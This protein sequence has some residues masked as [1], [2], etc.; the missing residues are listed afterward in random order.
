VEPAQQERVHCFDRES[1]KPLWTHAYPVSYGGV[2]Y[3]AGPRASVTVHDGRA[4]A[5][6]A[7][8]NLACLDA[9]SGALLWSRDL[10][11]DYAIQMP[12]WGI[13]AAPLVEG[14]V[15]ILQ[16]GGK[17]ACIVGLDRKSGADRW[18]ALPD[19]ASYSAPIT[20]DQEGKRVVVC[21]TGDRVVGLDPASGALQWEFPFPA[22]R[23]P[24]AIATPVLDRGRL[25]FTSAIDG[26]LM[27]R[28]VPGRLAV[29]KVWQRRG[30]SERVTDS[31]H[32]LISTPI[33]EG[34]HLYGIDH[35]G[36]L[37]CLDA[38]TGDRI[39]ESLDVM[40]QARWATAHLVR[41]GDRTWILNER[42]EL[43][44]ARLT[45][46]G[47]RELSRARLLGPTTGQLPQRGGVTWSH[48]AFAHGH[49]FA[50][51]DNELVCAD[52]RK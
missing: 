33:L 22:T 36:E 34:D 13:A 48:P 16:I 38:K 31:L 21:L 39:W 14:D 17:D 32:G 11:R 23:W 26:S 30:P 50:R 45:P 52:L 41:N 19:R 40:P 49:V 3:P 4:Y 8:G 5:L 18:R 9:E 7:V 2:G 15:V 29:E 35:Y 12:N 20:I 28:L 10:N 51:N 24:I 43:I 44:I 6:G 1:G 27:L 37:R 25:F 42:G 46:Q 47:Y